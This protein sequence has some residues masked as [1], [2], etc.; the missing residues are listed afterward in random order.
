MVTS[1]AT[2]AATTLWRAFPWDPAALAGSPFSARS[3]APAH[4]QNYGRFDLSG[5]PLVLYLAETPAHAVAEVLRGLKGS[6]PPGARERHRVTAADLRAQRRRRA[7]VSARLPAGA[8]EEI[9]DLT[10]GATL[11]ALGIRADHLAS[12]ERRRT[13]AISRTV[14]TA[15]YAGLRWWSV[16]HG[17]WHTTV[18][19]LDRIPLEQIEFGTPEPLSLA[20]PAVQEAAAALGLKVATAPPRPGMPQA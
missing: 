14:H 2:P 7:L 15:G 8:G 5:R 19:F 17:D 1:A 9:A 13:Q 11:A 20:H 18:V 10:D 3:V 6:L 4:A 16:L 12:R